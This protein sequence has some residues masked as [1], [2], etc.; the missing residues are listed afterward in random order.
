MAQSPE[1]STRL[2]K[3][4][5]K[6][7]IC[8]VAVFI[9]YTLAGFLILPF[10]LKLILTSKLASNLHRPVTI[11]SVRINP[12]SLTFALKGLSV[13][14]HSGEGVFASLGEVYIDLQAASI[15]KRGLVVK[16]FWLKS[17]RLSIVRDTDMTYNF[18]DLI[19]EKEAKTK[20]TEDEGKQKEALAFS[21]NN[22]QIS[23]GSIEFLDLAK[24][25]THHIR[26]INTNIPFISNMPSEV[27]SFVKPSFSAVF[28]ETNFRFEGSTKPFSDSLET[29][30]KIK[31]EKLFI[32]HYAAYSPVKM[33][34]KLAS[35][36]LSTDATLSYIQYRDKSPSLE[37]SGLLEIKDI[38]LRDRKG[39]AMV[40]LALFRVDLATAKLFE[41]KIHLSSVLIENPRINAVRNKKGEI[42]LLT[43]VPEQDNTAEEINKNTNDKPK[44]GTGNTPEITISKVTLKNGRVRFADYSLKPPFSVK[45]TGINGGLSGLSTSGGKAANAKLTAKIDRYVPLSIT[46][47]IDPFGTELFIDLKCKLGGF[48]LSSVTPYSGKFIGYTIEKGKLVLDLKYR[49]DKKKLNASNVVLID[50]ITLGRRVKSADATKLPI[51]FALRLLKDRRGEIN[52]DLPVTGRTDDPKFSVGSVV[53]K[54]FV[55]LISKAV[56]SPFALI[57]AIVGGGEELSFIELEPG[58]YTLTSANI[59]KLDTL[60]SALFERP[61]LKMEIGGYADVE[62]DRSVVMNYRLLNKIKAQKF[63]KVAKKGVPSELDA[64]TIEAGEY[65][66]YLWKAYK[67]EKFEKPKNAFGLTKKIKP[68]EMKE[69]MLSHITV[70]DDE[71]REL[72]TRRSKAVKDYILGSGKIEASR[73]FI[74]WPK[75][76]TPKEKKDVSQSRVEFK[77][78]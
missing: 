50:Q 18:A 20:D 40:D 21:I 5:R 36:Y 43:L 77:L 78:K 31:L 39:R 74:V 38:L 54:M 69:L 65:D 57:G 68:T 33:D 1:K 4:A 26:D 37:L 46:G 64:L 72:A 58:S 61:S 70:T 25:V 9:L 66:K 17:P 67:K 71:L 60:T 11:E 62:K 63:R 7:L 75:N 47:K 23:N 53:F 3:R 52:I 13:A 2:G 41:K 45:L 10:T 16:E 76:L 59:K 19:P 14:R 34:Y 6:A 56:T 12:Y 49:I 51:K 29:T 48:E 30:F 73:I 24:D 22:I 27:N 8:I 35:G 15:L 55:N 32:P 28:N 44:S 42:N